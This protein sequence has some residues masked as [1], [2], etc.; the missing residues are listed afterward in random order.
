MGYDREPTYLHP[1][2][3]SR[4]TAILD[5]INEPLPSG[6]EAKLVSAHRTPADQF[7]LFK[8][9]RTFRNGS[10]IKTGSVVTNLDGYIKRS[11]HNFLPCTAFDVGIFNNGNYLADSPL[12]QH[13]ARGKSQVMDW[14]GDWRNFKDRPHL[15]MPATSFF[16][17]NIDKDSGLMWQ[18]YLLKAGT[19]SG[20]MDGIFGPTSVRSLLETTGESTR[21]LT[22]WDKLVDQFGLLES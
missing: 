15:E 21:N 17:N 18:K 7:A 6:H 13:V 11:R 22:A 12:Y 10:W 8:N 4:L 20:A 2:I 9:G 5:A 1:Y 16:K 3:A 19:Y 14:G